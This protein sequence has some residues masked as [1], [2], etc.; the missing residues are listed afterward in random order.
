M[1]THT[2]IW[3]KFYSR[4]WSTITNNNNKR[5][6]EQDEI[7]LGY[8][9]LQITRIFHLDIL[10][11]VHQ[12]TPT[13]STSVLLQIHKSEKEE[14]EERAEQPW[15]RWDNS[16]PERR[17]AKMSTQ[18]SNFRKRRRERER[19][20]IQLSTDPLNN[21]WSRWNSP[22]F[23]MFLVSILKNSDLWC[24]YSKPCLELRERKRITM[25]NG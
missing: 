9:N 25:K 8:T 15:P 1:L 19:N 20:R 6:R 7:T 23:W 22:P 21:F 10:Q 18:I 4:F 16:Q 11:H 17:V 12:L 3:K 5:P 14:E 2:R 24:C 13:A